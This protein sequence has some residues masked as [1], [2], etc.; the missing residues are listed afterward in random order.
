M[1]SIPWEFDVQLGAW[2]LTADLRDLQLST[3]MFEG[4]ASKVDLRLPHPSG[5]VPIHF[6]AGANDVRP[7][8]PY[9]SSYMTALPS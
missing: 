3:V 8:W 7:G 2:R 9:V 6:R 1:T 4:G 5:T